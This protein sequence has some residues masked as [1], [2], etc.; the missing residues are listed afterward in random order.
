MYVTWQ[1]VVCV[2]TCETAAGVPATYATKALVQ[3]LAQNWSASADVLALA[4]IEVDLTLVPEGRNVTFKWRGKPLFVRHR[5][6]DEITREQAVTPAALRDPQLDT[7]RC[8][9][10]EWLVVLGV[11]TH[12]GRSL[13]VLLRS[14]RI[15]LYLFNCNGCVTRPI[16]ID[17]KGHSSFWWPTVSANKEDRLTTSIKSMAWLVGRLCGYP[18]TK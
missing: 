3:D 2:W 4:K 9:R 7:D 8:K 17:W 15:S 12:L 5:T 10:P 18:D 16:I 13:S 14:P 1:L 11:C 6:P